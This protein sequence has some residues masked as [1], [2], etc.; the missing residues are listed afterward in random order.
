MKIAQVSP[1]YESVPPRLYGGTERI[2]HYLTE[3]LV[4]DG[5]DVTLFAS[6]DSS[7]RARLEAIVPKALRLDGRVVDALAPHILMFDRVMG[8]ADQ[9]DVIHFHTDYL[10][11]PTFRY[12]QTPHLTTFHGRLDL[13][14][15]QPL[16]EAF[17][18]FPV[19]SISDFQRRPVRQANWLGTVHHGLPEHLYTFREKPGNYLVFLGRI[20][21]EKRPDRAI[22]IAMR[23]GMPLKI[24]AKVDKVDRDYFEDRIKPLLNH[25]LVEFIGE[26]NEQEKNELLG[27]AWALLFPIDWPEPFGLVMI[28]ALACGTPVVAFGQGSVPE[29]LDDGVTGF[30]VDSVEAAVAAVAAVERIDRARCRRVFE[31][32]FSARRMARDYVELYTRLIQRRTGLNV[33]GVLNL[34]AVG[35]KVKPKARQGGI[36][37]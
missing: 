9:F 2:V 13:H 20:S 34:G 22:E 19:V 35:L 8:M 26:V 30:I 29:V 21:P 11:F 23:V 14:D 31:S 7:T 33:P 36:S 4:A 1:L 28:E 24:A 18:D 5:H 15:L 16:F 10:Q 3:E 32:R 6:G 27:H 37:S 25:P 12:C 17:Q